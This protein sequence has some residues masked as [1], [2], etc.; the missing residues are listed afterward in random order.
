[1]VEYS[2]RFPSSCL[3]GH[4]LQTF[5]LSGIVL[6]L[7][8]T[9]YDSSPCDRSFRSADRF[10]LGSTGTIEEKCKGCAHL[11]A[12]VSLLTPLSKFSSGPLKRGRSHS[13][14]QLQ[15]PTNY[16]LLDSIL[17]ILPRKFV[18]I[19]GIKKLRD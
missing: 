10:L 14:F 6:K 8:I 3:T 5:S 13:E 17:S 19:G 1:M 12:F 18:A 9:A 16:A 7:K 11:I 2:P 4:V 15:L